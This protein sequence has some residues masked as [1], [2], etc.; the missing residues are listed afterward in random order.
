MNFEFGPRSLIRLV[1]FWVWA[2]QICR[3]GEILGVGL[4]IGLDLI[5]IKKSEKFLV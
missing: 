3:I 1:G 4:V 2:S 5:K